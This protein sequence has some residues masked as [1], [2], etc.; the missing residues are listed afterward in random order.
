[1]SHPSIWQLAQNAP[2][3]WEQ[4]FNAA[5]NDLQHISQQIE[6]R[7]IYEQLFCYPPR[8]YLFMAFH[9]T[10]LNQVKVVLLGQDPYPNTYYSRL[11]GQDMPNAH[12]ASFSVP[13]DAPI[14]SSLNNIYKEL[15]ASYGDVFTV[16]NH[17]YLQCW[18]QQGVLLINKCLTVLPGKKESDKIIWDSFITHVIQGINRSNPHCVYLLLGK[19]AQTIKHNIYG[20]Y[21]LE[22]SHP[23]GLSVTRGEN[24]FLG[25]RIFL[26]CN[27][28]LQSKGITPINWNLPPLAAYINN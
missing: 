14:P 23:S 11:C 17:G 9:W 5:A 24:P 6:N 15:K 12:G 2:A 18:A 19:K 27:A 8:P 22:C 1:M 28:Y 16:P 3:G 13:L 10:P 4:V 7:E 20:G 26:L 25:S 21:I